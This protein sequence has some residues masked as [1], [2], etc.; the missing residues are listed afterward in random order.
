MLVHSQ[1][2]ELHLP[3]QKIKKLRSETAKLSAPPT[4]REVSRLLGKLN[5]VS[6]AVTPGPLFCRMIQRDLATALDRGGQSYETPCPLSVAA[7]EELSWWT[8]Q[9][10]RWNGKSLVLRNIDLTLESDA[11]RTGWGASCQGVH[12]GGP[13]SPQERSYHINC[14][15]LLA[16]SLVVKTFMKGL[17]NK[18]VLLLLDNQTV[19]AYINNLGGTVSAQAMLIARNLWMWCLERDILLSAQHLPGKKNIAADSESRV[20]KDRYDWMLNESVFRRVLNCFPYLNVNLFASRLTAQLQRFFSWRPDPLA[21]ATDAFLQ[22]W[23]GL[24]G[25]ANPPW[26]LIGRVLSKVEEQRVDVILSVANS[27][28]V[29]QAPQSTDCSRISH[30]PELVWEAREGCLPELLPQLAVWPISGNTMSTRSFLEKL[31]TSSSLHGDRNQ[32]SLTIRCVKSGSAGVLK[33]TVIPFQD[34]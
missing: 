27:T 21:E 9:L 18:R 26:S 29:S 3:G 5:S 2:L 12:T 16:A 19:V 20:M 34:L 30:Q 17:T 15:E 25:Y 11:S 14:L 6:H 8:E 4:V 32:H 13:W 22:D 7:K 23:R 33:G 31:Q 1:T 24:S 10:T 28:L